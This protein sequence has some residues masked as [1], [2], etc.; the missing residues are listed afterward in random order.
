MKNEYR[1]RGDGEVWIIL[2]EEEE[3]G[4]LV[5]EADFDL[6]WP[7]W[8]RLRKGYAISSTGIRMSRLIMGDPPDLI[9][10]HIDGDRLDNRRSNLRMATVQ[11]NAA[12]CHR[13]RKKNLCKLCGVAL[14]PDL[15]TY[16]LS[17]IS[18]DQEFLG[19]IYDMTA[20]KRWGEFAKRKLNFPD[21]QWELVK[22]KG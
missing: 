12:N 13:Q 3:V 1:Y 9:V 18:D 20:R 22:V 19:R 11:Q 7:F 5:D 4:C 6:V 15:K 21:E 2:D 14:L 16:Q 17:A 10:D 8:W